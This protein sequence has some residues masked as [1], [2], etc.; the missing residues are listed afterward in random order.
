M[1]MAKP[2]VSP[3]CGWGLPNPASNLTIVKLAHLYQIVCISVKT[4][5]W[6]TFTN[7]LGLKV[8]FAII[9]VELLKCIVILLSPNMKCLVPPS[10]GE[11]VLELLLYWRVDCWL[12]T[13][14]CWLLQVDL[15]SRNSV[16]RRDSLLD[17]D[18]DPDDDLPPHLYIGRHENQL[19]I[20]ESILLHQQAEQGLREYNLNPTGSEAAFPRV[21]WKPYL[22]SRE[23]WD[24]I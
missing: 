12:L 20:Q 11:Q 1:D 22:V 17:D 18:D 6:A 15:F 3:N 10:A 9:F 4:N 5:C 2:K 19:Y 21:S 8:Y 16:P 13:V 14:D 24:L 7:P 23:S